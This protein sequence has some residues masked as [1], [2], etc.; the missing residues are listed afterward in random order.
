MRNGFEFNG[1]NTT[2]FK[3]VTVRT[4]DRPVFP[5][6]KEFTVSADETDG[7]YDFTD[8]FGCI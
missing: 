7:E 4:K 6:V 5:Q 3:R 1:K 2:D 8:V